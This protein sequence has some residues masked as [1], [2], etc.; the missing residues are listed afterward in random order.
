[1]ESDTCMSAYIR[2]YER[3]KPTQTHNTHKTF[4]LSLSRVG[5]NVKVHRGYYSVP[6]GGPGPRPEDHNEA[7]WTHESRSDVKLFE[8]TGVRVPHARNLRIHS[9][10]HTHIM[11]IRFVCIFPH[12]DIVLP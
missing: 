11:S 2:K 12:H 4:S 8:L 5:A 6:L 7:G 10:I 3:D 9:Y 1:M